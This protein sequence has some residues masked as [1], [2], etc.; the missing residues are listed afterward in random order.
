MHRPSTHPTAGRSGFT[1]IELLV[2][3]AI[4]GILAGM[5]LPAITMA[6]EQARRVACGNNQRQIVLA[7][8]AYANGSD[9][10]W[11]ARPTSADG[12]FAAAGA[13]PATGLPSNDWHTTFASLEWLAVSTG[14]ELTPGTFLC[15]SAATYKPVVLPDE[16]MTYAGTSKSTWATATGTSILPYAYDWTVP[17][18]ARSTRVVIADRGRDTTAHGKV[19]MAAF[20]DGH[21]AAID[22]AEGTGSADSTKGLN[23][24]ANLKVYANTSAKNDNI[25][26]GNGDDEL[27]AVAGM[28]SAT[29]CILR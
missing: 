5:L 29:R 28:G 25:Y 18:N 1:L 20:A 16:D 22:Q 14:K 23:G 7:C 24:K 13:D 3:V 10:A 27:T 2:V 11:P 26:D 4:I 8:R 12:T 19:A 9:G 17:A 6:I 15:R 21:V